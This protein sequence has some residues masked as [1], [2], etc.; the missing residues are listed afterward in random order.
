MIKFRTDDFKHFDSK[1]KLLIVKVSYFDSKSKL[2][3]FKLEVPITSQRS[4]RV[5]KGK[6][7]DSSGQDDKI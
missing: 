6:S 5:L 3:L 4:S 7:K 2:L 1:S